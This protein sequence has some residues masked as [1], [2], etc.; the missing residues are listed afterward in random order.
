ML[1]SIVSAGDA[2]VVMPVLLSICYGLMSAA[3]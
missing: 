2:G 3:F 1:G